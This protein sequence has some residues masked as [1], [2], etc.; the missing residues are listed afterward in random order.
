[1]EQTKL[2]ELKRIAANVRLG[3]LECVYSAASGHPGGAL[4]IADILT[5]LYFAHMHID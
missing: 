4:S 5:Y 3:A 2:Q 1:M